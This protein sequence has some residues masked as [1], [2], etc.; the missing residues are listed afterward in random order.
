MSWQEEALCPSVDPHLFFPETTEEAKTAKTLCRGC[1]V[2][3]E[4]LAYA[5]KNNE[6][7]GVWGGTT[8]NERKAM[9]RQGRKAA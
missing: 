1:D 7:H 2:I 8:P 4:C 6:Q 5:L 3:E 9:L